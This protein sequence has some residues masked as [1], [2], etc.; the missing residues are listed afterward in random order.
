METTVRLMLCETS[1]ICADA[2]PFVSETDRAEAE[3]CS[4]PDDKI[5]RL[6]S[7]C[8]KRKYIGSWSIGEHGKPVADEKFFN[9]SHTKGAVILALADNN[10]GVDI[11]RIRPIDK[12]FHAYVSDPNERSVITND[13]TFFCVWTAKESL[14]KAAGTG[15]DLHPKNVPVLPL[16]GT[17]TFKNNV[18]FSQQTVLGDL[19]VSVTRKGETPF[20]LVIEKETFK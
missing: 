15:F 11:E 20:S 2:L 17:K 13:E 16:I 5:V 3:R 1:D 7:L 19:V 12:N 8:L 14:V 9:V 4:Q 18:Y 10:V 6:V